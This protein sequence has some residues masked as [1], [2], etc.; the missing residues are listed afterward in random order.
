MSACYRCNQNQENSYFWNL[1]KTEYK[2]KQVLRDYHV[3]NESL[4]PTFPCRGQNQLKRV[5]YSW[6]ARILSFWC[7]SSGN[8]NGNFPL[9][10][11]FRQKHLKQT[12]RILNLK[13]SSASSPVFSCSHF[14]NSWNIS[15]TIAPAL[16]KYLEW[17]S[18]FENGRSIL[19][20]TGWPGNPSGRGFPP[21]LRPDP[22]LCPTRDPPVRVS[23]TR[24]WTYYVPI[25]TPALHI[26]GPRRTSG[27]MEVRCFQYH[28][29]C[30]IQ[31]GSL[32]A[33]EYRSRSFVR[34]FAYSL[35]GCSFARICMRLTDRLQI[36]ARLRSLLQ[37]SFL[38]VNIQILQRRSSEIHPQKKFLNQCF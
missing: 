26:H 34:S 35:F 9:H 12:G 1:W 36:H 30:W 22:E 14:R 23:G 19:R 21:P 29:N 15:A 16:Y 20:L 28:A 5:G 11:R 7:Y 10:S 18:K 6:T 4:L 31:L 38:L 2:N 32:D 25:H 27:L 24:H 17:K 33:M 37:N 3:Q 8:I 13:S